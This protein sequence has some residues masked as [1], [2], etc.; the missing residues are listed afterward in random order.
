MSTRLDRVLTSIRAQ[1]DMT[2][3]IAIILGSGLGDYAEQ[4]DGV[5]VSYSDIAGFPLSSAPSHKGILHIGKLHGRNVAAFQGR[6]HL[7]EGHTAQDTAFPVEV[8]HS[9]GARNVILTNISGSLNPTYKNG[10]IIGLS[11]HIYLPGLTGN[12]AL[13]GRC[14]ESCSPFVNLTRTYDQYWLETMELRKSGIYACLAGPQFETPAEGR[15]LRN[16]GADMVGMST[17]H[18]AVMAR[19]LQMRVLGLSLIVNPV[20]TDIETQIEVDESEIW[21]GVEAAIPKFSELVDRAVLNCPSD[22][23]PA[24]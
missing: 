1:T 9:L 10:E 3:D 22:Q 21:K 17:I 19:Y 15:M 24:V 23:N 2:A 4:I 6:L 7:Y 18:E 11:D 13:V 20:I 8:A 12:G 5:S 14:R 16:M